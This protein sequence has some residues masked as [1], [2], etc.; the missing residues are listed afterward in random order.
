MHAS[1][2]MHLVQKGKILQGVRDSLQQISLEEKEKANKEA[3]QGDYQAQGSA[4]EAQQQGEIRPAAG[5]V[6]GLLPG[7]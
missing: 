3:Q 6:N 1:A 4:Q 7:W 2:T 5:L